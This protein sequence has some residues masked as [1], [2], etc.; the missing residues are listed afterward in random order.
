MFNYILSFQFFFSFSLMLMY[1]LLQAES[2]C[3]G[4]RDKIRLVSYKLVI[5]LVCYNLDLV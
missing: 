1:C 2:V 4:I 3:G 5:S